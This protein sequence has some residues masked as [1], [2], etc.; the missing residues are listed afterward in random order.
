[1]KEV[2]RDSADPVTKKSL[3]DAPPRRRAA[4]SGG[5]PQI[6]EFHLGALGSGS[7]YVAF[8]DQSGSLV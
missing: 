7:D 3:L 4:P 2:M 6:N 8:V 5:E 1:M